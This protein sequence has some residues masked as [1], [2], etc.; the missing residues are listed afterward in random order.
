MSER[1]GQIYKMTNSVDDMVYIGSTTAL[2]LNDRLCQHKYNARKRY[3][4]NKLYDH[5]RHVGAENC[6]IHLIKKYFTISKK[7]LEQKEYAEMHKYDTKMLLNTN[8]E[9][10][11]RSDEYLKN[12]RLARNARGW[13]FHRDRSKQQPKRGDS[14]E[15]QWYDHSNTK[16]ERKSKV[17][18]VQ[19]YGYE[20]AWQLAEDYRNVKF[21]TL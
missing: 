17:W 18:S 5:M 6:T 13:I 14:I 20:A 3:D 8:T 16:A 15:Y 12:W 11:K 2:L 4:N 9:Y 10:K 1:M 19:K 7:K 21:P